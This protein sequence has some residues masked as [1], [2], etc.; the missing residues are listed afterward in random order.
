MKP[1]KLKSIFPFFLQLSNKNKIIDHYYIDRYI[2]CTRI[3]LLKIKLYYY[4]YKYE[5]L[6]IYLKIKKKKK[7][8]PDLSTIKW[9]LS[10]F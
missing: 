5:L 4:I 9:L 1:F 6:Q 10:F 3:N 8:S 7:L 2:L